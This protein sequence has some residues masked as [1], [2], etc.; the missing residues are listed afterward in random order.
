MPLLVAVGGS[1]FLVV[2]LFTEGAGLGQLQHLNLVR[3]GVPQRECDI[4]QQFFEGLLF[5]KVYAEK[6]S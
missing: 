3:H 5:N 4:F 6:G 1:S 2:L